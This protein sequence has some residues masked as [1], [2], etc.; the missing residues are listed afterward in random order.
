MKKKLWLSLLVTALVAT[1][2]VATAC[3]DSGE[4]ASP[5]GESVSASASAPTGS[6]GNSESASSSE[7]DSSSSSSDSESSSTEPETP[8]VDPLTL[9]DFIVNIPTGKEPVVLQLS[10]TQIIDAAQAR[11]GR[12]GVDSVFWATDQIE[13]RCYDY[14]TE[15]IETVAPDFIII[16]GDVVYGEFDD[17]GTALE[18]FVSFMD[19]FKIPWSPVF[20]NHDNES[21]KG[22][23]YWR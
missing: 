21:A 2:V 23:V 10:D 19:G 4:S 20:G 12:G 3:A 7:K 13:E 16:T 11:P 8:S 6:V 18:S 14:L 5:D 1:S 15:T 9:P 22:V 17:S